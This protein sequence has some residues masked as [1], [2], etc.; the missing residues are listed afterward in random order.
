M[1][2][3]RNEAVASV[4]GAVEHTLQALEEKEEKEEE[5]KEPAPRTPWVYPSITTRPAAIEKSFN[6][7]IRH[8]L[9]TTQV[10]LF[11]LPYSSFLIY[12]FC[13]SVCPFTPLP[14]I[15]VS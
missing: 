8:S 9:G 2:G 1:L 7:K 5:K 6:G 3:V 12:F 10:F 4:A 13:L 14:T 15:R 11:S